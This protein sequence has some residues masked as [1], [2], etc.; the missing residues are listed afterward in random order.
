MGKCTEIS[1][2]PCKRKER[3]KQAGSMCEL[4]AFEWQEQREKHRQRRGSNGRRMGKVL[5]AG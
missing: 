1:T 2:Y 4:S 5:P 3:R